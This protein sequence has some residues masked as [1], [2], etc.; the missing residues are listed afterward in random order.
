MQYPIIVANWKMY[1]DDGAA[2]A[3]ARHLSARSF[4]GEGKVVLCP[5]FPALREV[6]EAIV[7][8]PSL[9]I[10]AQDVSAE[11][12][13]PYTGDVAASELVESGC[14]F[15]IV[16][17]SE[18]RHRL[19]ETDEMIRQ[20]IHTATAAGLVPILCVGETESERKGGH[21]EDV[22]KGQVANALQGNGHGPVV[23]AYEPVWAIGSG[24]SDHPDD[25]RRM[26]DIILEVA[27]QNG[28]QDVAV[29]YGGSVTGENVA[30]FV[31]GVSLHGVL[32]GS[33]STDPDRFDRVLE[34][35]RV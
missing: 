34:A 13:G 29:L 6:H 4:V 9:A 21:G 30:S 24:Q 20:K 31:D 5:S 27:K 32:V 11:S 25:A 35:L 28:A 33:A 3:L 16:G 22:V 10:G 17:H 15:V 1:L 12:S 19:G 26:A 18:R 23:L 14:Q 8:N 2:V 7:G